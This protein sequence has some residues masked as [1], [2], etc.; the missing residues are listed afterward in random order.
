MDST[1]NYWG[2]C[3]ILNTI[4]ILTKRGTD[5]IYAVIPTKYQKYP[6]TTILKHA[7]ILAKVIKLPYRNLHNMTPHGAY[8]ITVHARTTTLVDIRQ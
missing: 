1:Q 8:S 3:D 6:S 5:K 4:I 2:Q 7:N